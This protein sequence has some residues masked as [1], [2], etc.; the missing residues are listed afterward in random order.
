M[1][2]RKQINQPDRNPSQNAVKHGCRSQV[3]FLSCEN[4]ADYERLWKT[5]LERYHPTS[6]AEFE[7]VTDV[8]DA[9]WR[10]QRSRRVFE[11]FEFSLLTKSPDPSTWTD[12]QTRRLMLLQRYKTADVNAFHKAIRLIEHHQRVD[13]RLHDDVERIAERV[14]QEATRPADHKAYKRT[15]KV[16]LLTPPP[17]PTD[18]KDGGC[19]CT[20]CV[21]EWGI[22]Y[23]KPPSTEG[24]NPD[25]PT[26]A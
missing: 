5:W 19:L 3:R 26:A 23:L 10:I 21:W 15:M 25:A 6:A 18:R 13:A 24:A 17:I 14:Y 12:E 1:T 7:L 4:P 22:A 20:P 2:M 11:T 16:Q 8:V 9:A